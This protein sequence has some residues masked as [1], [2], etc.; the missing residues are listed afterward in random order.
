MDGL[1]FG[2]VSQI[3]RKPLEYRP[4]PNRRAL[5]RTFEPDSLIRPD[6]SW[7]DLEDELAC[8]SSTGENACSDAFP[9]DSVLA[10]VV[11]PELIGIRAKTLRALQKKNSSVLVSDL[12][13]RGYNRLEPG[14]I[15]LRIA[16]LV[17]ALEITRLLAH[18]RPVLRNVRAIIE[19]SHLLDQ[20]LPPVSPR[21]RPATRQARLARHNFW[22]SPDAVSRKSRH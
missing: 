13:L 6:C 8:L 19:G 4:I 7:A 18:Q 3:G 21:L 15:S 5:A 17:V 16:C 14:W 9:A 12:D 22:Q 10:A 2:K 11:R 1:K 20:M